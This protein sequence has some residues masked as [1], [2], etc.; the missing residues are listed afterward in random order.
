MPK[1]TL[2]VIIKA[3]SAQRVISSHPD[4]ATILVVDYDDIIPDS[5]TI[6]GNPASVKADIII[7]GNETL[8][9]QIIAAAA[10]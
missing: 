1:P 10:A 3:G 2:A 9:N 7:D 8:L 5:P 6:D 4:A